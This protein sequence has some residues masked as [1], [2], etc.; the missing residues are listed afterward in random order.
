MTYFISFLFQCGRAAIHFFGWVDGT[1]V[2]QN[3]FRYLSERPASLLALMVHRFAYPSVRGTLPRSMNSFLVTSQ[4]CRERPG[5]RTARIHPRKPRMPEL[6]YVDSSCVSFRTKSAKTFRGGTNA[7]N[8][9]GRM[10]MKSFE[11]P[12]MWMAP[13]PLHLASHAS[14]HR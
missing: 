2:R 12:R 13:A 9:H 8:H 6:F 11:I 3:L 5:F 4:K 10:H 14:Q 7:A 1:S